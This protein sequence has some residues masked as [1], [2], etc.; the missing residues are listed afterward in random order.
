[1]KNKY[2]IAVLTSGKSRGTNFEA[3]AEH[4]RR[5]KLPINIKFLVITTLDSPIRI[6][7]RK[8]SIRELYLPEKSSFEK[9]LLQELHKCDVQ[10]LALDGFM[11]KLSADFIR[12]FEGKII[13]IHPALLPKYGGQGMYG[14]RVH[15]S[16]FNNDEQLSG[17]SVHYVNEFYDDGEIVDQI[18]INISG[19]DSPEEIAEKVLIV[20]HELY[21]KVIK[22]F[23]NQYLYP[24]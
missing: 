21:P 11:R 22:S 10:L 12:K 14:M 24:I 9:E 6:K 19:C 2:N 1:M 23:A 20:E 7:A 3:I 17:A 8:H 16:V 5:N 4:I 18:T 13:N 15:Q